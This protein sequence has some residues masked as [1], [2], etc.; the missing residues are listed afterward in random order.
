MKMQRSAMGKTRRD[1]IRNDGI[2]VIVGLVKVW[3]KAQQRR[4][5]W[6]VRRG[7][8]NIWKRIMDVQM[9]DEE[10]PR[11]DRGIILQKIWSRKDCRKD[12]SNRKLWNVEEKKTRHLYHLILR[13]LIL[14]VF[15][16][17]EHLCNITSCFFGM[18]SNFTTCIDS[19]RLTYAI[20][21]IK[22]N[23]TYILQLMHK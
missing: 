5:S 10:S 15:Y 14:Y 18:H 4:L 6:Y 21:H 2:Q 13:H 9:K 19:S 17:N 16:L 11:D 1:R 12:S 20:P 3:E 22:L 8:G 23:F 7:V